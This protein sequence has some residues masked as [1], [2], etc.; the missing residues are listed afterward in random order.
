LFGN[1]S[2]LVWPPIKILSFHQ[3]LYFWFIA[4]IYFDLCDH[5]KILWCLN[6]KWIIDREGLSWNISLCDLEQSYILSFL[7]R[8]SS[9]KDLLNQSKITYFKDPLML[10]PQDLY[11]LSKVLVQNFLKKRFLIFFQCRSSFFRESFILC[12]LY[13]KLDYHSISP[14]FQAFQTSKSP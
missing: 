1:P 11:P 6:R 9:N 4:S 14:C 7:G 5:V 8:S 2:R 3:D 13:R 10:S 12:E